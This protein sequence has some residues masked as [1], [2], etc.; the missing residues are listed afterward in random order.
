MKRIISK[1]S[2]LEE[3]IENERKMNEEKKKSYVKLLQEI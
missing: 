3:Q 1:V 2:H